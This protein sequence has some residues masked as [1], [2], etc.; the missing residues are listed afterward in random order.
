MTTET[1]IFVVFIIFFFFLYF[2]K[3]FNLAIRESVIILTADH[4]EL[5]FT[6]MV[7]VDKHI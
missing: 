7:E 2:R 5:T 4:D 1:V 6:C 3:I